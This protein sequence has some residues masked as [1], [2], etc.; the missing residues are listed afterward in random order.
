MITLPPLRDR[1]KDI[2]L[3]SNHFLKQLSKNHQSVIDIQ[4]EKIF[5][6]FTINNWRGNVREL[7]NFCEHL[8]VNYN[9]ID[10][11]VVATELEK[12]KS[13]LLQKSDESL[14]N[15]LKIQ[16]FN[17]ATNEF[18]RMYLQYHLKKNDNHVSKTAKEIGVD[19]GTIYYKLKKKDYGSINL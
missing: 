19:R 2:L 12:K 15:L 6:R 3:L 16:N 17:D 4:L 5:D 1:G 7:Y 14:I 11:T 9:F 8:V 18:E 13:G 10:N